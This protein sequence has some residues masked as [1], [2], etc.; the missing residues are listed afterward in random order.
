MGRLARLA[1]MG[2]VA[3]AGFWSTNAFEIGLLKYPR[4]VVSTI[5]RFLSAGHPAKQ[6]RRKTSIVESLICGD[7]IKQLCPVGGFLTLKIIDFK[8]QNR[9]E[10]A[11]WSK[12]FLK[13]CKLQ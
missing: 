2:S 7:A 3:P 1:R 10:P 5:A 12:V 11:F 6:N 13:C 8:K 9:P 4:N